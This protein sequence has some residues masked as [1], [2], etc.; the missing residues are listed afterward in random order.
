MLNLVMFCICTLFLFVLSWGAWAVLQLAAYVVGT[1][2]AYGVF[3]A[4][5]GVTLIAAL[6][7]R[8]KD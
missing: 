7:G 3:G 4:C 2:V 8:S 6:F 5:V 1:H